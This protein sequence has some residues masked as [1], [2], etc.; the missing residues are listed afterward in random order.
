M[1]LSMP[2]F[3]QICLQPI[4]KKRKRKKKEK[5]EEEEG[6]GKEEDTSQREDMLFSF[7]IFLV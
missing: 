6:E 4:M 3:T 2:K 5:E 1:S 7:S